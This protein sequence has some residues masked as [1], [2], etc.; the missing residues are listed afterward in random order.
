MKITLQVSINV[1]LALFV[2]ACNSKNDPV[3][4][5]PGAIPDKISGTITPVGTVT[6]AAVTVKI[7]PN[8]GK[9]ESVD[10]RI[11]ISIPAGALE[12]EQ[13]IS[14]QPLTN[15]CPAGKGNA[16]R[17][18]PHGTTFSEPVSITFQY[19]ET[20]TNGSTPD[21]LR[22]AYQ[23]K[24]GIWQSP[25]V[26]N[27]DTIASEVTIE[28]T[29]FSDWALFQ[30]MYI[31]P[32]QSTLNPG[33]HQQLTVLQ[34]IDVG[35]PKKEYALI[36]AEPLSAK[37]IEK[38]ALNGEGL[39]TPQGSRAYYHAPSWIPDINPAAVSVFFNKS[40]TIN[41]KEYKNIRLVSNILVAPEGL[42]VQLDRG[43]WHT[44]PGGANINGTLNVI[45]GRDGNESA[46]VAWKGGP[47]GTFHWTKGPDVT[48]NLVKPKINYMH[49]YGLG[50]S[51][52]GGLLTVDN[53]DETWVTG[54]FTV[55]PAGWI[56]RSKV[57]PET[58]VSS[59]KGV[60]RVRRID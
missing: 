50:P 25:R 7:G 53:S 48:F 39:L 14:L 5:S 44:Y 6:G 59:V 22:L 38:W 31:E 29:H 56:D 8:G 23:D 24:K 54:T 2:L 58:G 9:L 18:L 40:L 4:P 34:T 32:K 19:R 13:T 17:I 11:R 16:F 49:L 42:S 52:S 28:T 41:G 43:D 12:T 47:T 3:I 45:L 57:K 1:L 21:F 37:Y 60:F 15:Q 30:A 36:M 20:D 46:S 35:D 26:K 27:L 33:G 10:H 51:L 55:S